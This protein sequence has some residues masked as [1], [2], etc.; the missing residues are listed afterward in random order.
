VA[1]DHASA[2]DQLARAAEI[3]RRGHLLAELPLI[4]LAQ[5]DL[6][7]RRLAWDSALRRAEEIVS[8]AAARRMRLH[9]ADAL[10]LRGGVRLD[11]ARAELT[12]NAGIA[13]QALDDATAART[14]AR[15]CGYTWAE[16]DSERLAAAAYDLLGDQERAHQYR[17]EAEALDARLRLAP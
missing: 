8:L 15:Q 7:R 4:L 12:D 17:R 3:L 1:G 9:H 10:A 11:R 2:A 16:R 5:A 6:D 13:Y 14:L